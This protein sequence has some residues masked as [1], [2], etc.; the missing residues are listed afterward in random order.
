MICGHY[1]LMMVVGMD[2]S[3]IIL[4]IFVINT[5]SMIHQYEANFVLTLR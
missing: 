1:V 2:E 5:N 3:L 4:L